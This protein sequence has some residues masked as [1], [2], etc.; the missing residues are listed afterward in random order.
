MQARQSPHRATIVVH[1]LHHARA[2]AAVAAELK[3]PVR[4]LSAPF[5]G[6]S[7]SPDVF[8]EMIKVAVSEYPDADIIA[9]LDCGDAPGVALAALRLGVK[10]VRIDTDNATREK[11]AEIAEQSDAIVDT[12]SGTSLDLLDTD[13]PHQACRNWLFAHG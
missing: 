13:D 1:T 9:V 8:R 11:L 5:A 10:A 7:L 12:W 2:A 6:I 4:L 3:I